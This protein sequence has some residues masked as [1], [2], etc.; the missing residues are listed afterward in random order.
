MNLVVIPQNRLDTNAHSHHRHV[1]IILQ[2]I[3]RIPVIILQ[4]EILVSL[5]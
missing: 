5:R 1:T 4:K 2:K 3:L